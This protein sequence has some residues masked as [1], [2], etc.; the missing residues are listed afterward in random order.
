V[1]WNLAPLFEFVEQE[2]KETKKQFYRL[3]NFQFFKKDYCW[4][5]KFSKS[6]GKFKFRSKSFILKNSSRPSIEKI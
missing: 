2:I 1:P 6:A 5:R 3:F 4:L